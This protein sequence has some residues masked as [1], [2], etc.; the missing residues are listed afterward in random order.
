MALVPLLPPLLLLLLLVGRPLP[1]VG[2]RIGGL[3]AKDRL[4]ELVA[5]ASMS[6]RVSAGQEHQLGGRALVAR[7]AV[8]G[9]VT[10]L[11]LA[12]S[13]MQVELDMS[14][15]SEEGTMLSV[16][17]TVENGDREVLMLGPPAM[18]ARGVKKDCQSV[19]KRRVP[20]LA[21]VLPLMGSGVQGSELRLEHE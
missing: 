11:L 6:H 12:G 2:G 21:R 8:G 20:R 9:R 4:L 15:P 3:A 7:K 1:P 16:T 13:D 17:V 5:A 14:H 18:P 19:A 10:V